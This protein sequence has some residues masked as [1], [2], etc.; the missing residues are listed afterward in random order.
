MEKKAVLFKALL[1]IVFLPLGGFSRTNSNVNFSEELKSGQK[2]F[3]L[4]ADQQVPEKISSFAFL[5]SENVFQFQVNNISAEMVG[6]ADD[7]GSVIA[8]YGH[9]P[10]LSW[11][12]PFCRSPQFP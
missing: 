5:E 12:S 3:I 4:Q 1:F 10:K 2:L 8:A 11:V 6:G 9:A 7:A